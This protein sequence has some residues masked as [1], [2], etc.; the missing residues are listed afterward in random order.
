MDVEEDRKVL[1]QFKDENGVLVKAPFDI[2]INITPT[3]LQSLCNALVGEVSIVHV[4]QRS[5]SVPVTDD[6]LLR[7]VTSGPLEAR[8]YRF[9]SHT[10]GTALPLFESE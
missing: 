3:L 8:S 9:M 5:L 1:A 4:P 10:E 6:W 7:L 2:P